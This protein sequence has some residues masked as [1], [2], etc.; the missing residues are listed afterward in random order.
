MVICLVQ[1]KF[2]VGYSLSCRSSLVMF[3]QMLNLSLTVSFML[4]SVLQ[5]VIL[6]CCF[7]LKRWV[8]STVLKWLNIL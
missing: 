4:L 8:H 7:F 2:E 6:G 1:V 5:P 3:T